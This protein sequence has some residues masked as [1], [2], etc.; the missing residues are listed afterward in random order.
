MDDTMLFLGSF[1]K[2]I[3]GLLPLETKA[4]YTSKCY[5]Q[6]K[7]TISLGKRERRHGSIDFCPMPLIKAVLRGL[8]FSDIG[9]LD[10]S[11]KHLLVREVH[12]QKH[13]GSHTSEELVG[14]CLNGLL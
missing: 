3:P 8:V 14:T 1:I 13:N 9:C 6:T 11:A 2:H 12:G 4:E 10:V 5:K 7:R